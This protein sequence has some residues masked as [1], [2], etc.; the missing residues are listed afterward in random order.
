MKYIL[1]CANEIYD[2]YSA[3]YFEGEVV[4]IDAQD[5]ILSIDGFQI[6]FVD[7]IVCVK[8]DDFETVVYPQ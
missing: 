8:G 1:E 7:Q 5:N 6:Q 3:A 4:T 2:T